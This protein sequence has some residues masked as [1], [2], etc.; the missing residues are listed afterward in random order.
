MKNEKK[1][2][3]SLYVNI[4][5][6]PNCKNLNLGKLLT[7]YINKVDNL[8]QTIEE[9]HAPIGANYRN[10]NVPKILGGIDNGIESFESFLKKFEL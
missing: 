3:D 1:C 4:A 9:A 10:V 5:V 6:P 2:A 7:N 8:V